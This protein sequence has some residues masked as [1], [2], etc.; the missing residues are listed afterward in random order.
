MELSIK[1]DWVDENNRVY[2]YFTLLN[3]WIMGHMLIGMVS[4][5]FNSD[6]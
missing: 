2:I 3:R 1:N 6:V 5:I 4:R